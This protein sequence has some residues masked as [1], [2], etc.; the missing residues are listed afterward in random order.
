[1]GEFLWG[2]EV[3]LVENHE[4]ATVLLKHLL[5]EFGSEACEPV[6]VG[7]HKREFISAM[8]SFQYGCKSFPSVVEPGC[9]IGYYLGTR[10]VFLHESDLALEVAGLLVAGDSAVAEG[11]LGLGIAQVCLDVVS[12][13]SALGLDGW[14]YSLVGVPAEG[15][16]VEAEYLC[17]LA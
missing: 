15:V 3:S 17:G 13:L 16:G 7:N 12:P 2:A 4:F 8:K 14:D 1:M 9:D 5:D 11:C 10:I 6:S